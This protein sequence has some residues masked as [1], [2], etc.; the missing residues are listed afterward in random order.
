MSDPIRVRSL[1]D[2]LSLRERIVE[3]LRDAILTGDLPAKTR[4]REPDLAQRL[5]VSRTPLREAIRQ[6]EAE[7]LVSTVPRGGAFVTTVTPQDLEETYAIRAVLE[8]LAARQAAGRVDPE[9]AAGLRALLDELGQKTANYRVYHEAAGRFHEA[10]FDLAG[11]KRL[12]AMYEALTRQVERLRK[13]SLAVGKRPDTSLR[14]HRRIA[15]AILRGKGAE[16]E[17]RMRAH[18]EGALGVLRRRIRAASQ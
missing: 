16:A 4:L 2:H 6:L 12:Q 14:E 13:V 8:G 15:D 10:I 1:G 18:I 3:R 9:Q 11:N 17:R 7:G 5:A